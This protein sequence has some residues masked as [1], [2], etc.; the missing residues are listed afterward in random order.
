MRKEFIM[1]L[2]VAASVSL[3]SQATVTTVTSSAD[4]GEGSLR[5]L[6]S[7]AA[8]GDTLSLTSGMTII[9]D[10]PIT[11]AQNVVINGNGSTI[12]V[13]TPGTS[14]YRLMMIGDN[15][16][17]PTVTI[18]DATLKGG[19]IA[20]TN[21]SASNIAN[22][23]GVLAVQKSTL[24][25]NNVVVRDG[26][27][28]YS[29]GIH[30]ADTGCK[31][32]LNNCTITNNSTATVGS[33][34]GSNAGAIYF[35]GEATVNN[36]LFTNNIVGGAGNGAAVVSNAKLTITNSQFVGNQAPSTGSYGSTVF[37]T[38]G[39]ISTFDGCLFKDNSSATKGAGAF[40]CS[41]ATPITT[42]TFT[43]CTFYNNSGVEGGALYIY[44]GIVDLINCTVTGNS[45]AA[46]TNIGAGV[47]LR[48]VT[49]ATLNLT[50]TIVAYNTNSGSYADLFQG[51]GSTLTGTHNILGN[52]TNSLTSPIAFSYSPESALFESY[53][54]TDVKTPVI[55]ND[56][57]V[58]LSSSSIARSS[59]CGY[60]QFDPEI[61]PG[62]DQI[63]TLRG[64][65]P[66]LGACEYVSTP[67]T[68]M[69]PGTAVEVSF[70]PNPAKDV[71]YFTN[72]ES[73]KMVRIV[74]IT[75]KVLMSTPLTGSMLSVDQLNGGIYILAIESANGITSQKL[76]IR[77]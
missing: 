45:S 13:A 76:N 46:T 27:G 43:N 75:G 4:A 36:C 39:G 1:S 62:K 67:S 57:T 58:K 51:T 77:K 33:V 24:T 9:L 41:T 29:G 73:I 17:T 22:C 21:S 34:N 12:Q 48:A 74:D 16:A 69:T 60:G 32:F 71:I 19:K 31:F 23:G 5:T 53:T 52:F 14:T 44:G 47:W 28:T 68:D 59:G 55:S 26:V 56:G 30:A 42:T 61:L 7:T 10:S 40:A 2:L 54:G 35:K 66:C 38:G 37:T 11:I 70:Y 15:V 25:L 49:N 6:L 72:W 3:T 63:G 20:G 65:T 8:S 50:N 64:T 18:N